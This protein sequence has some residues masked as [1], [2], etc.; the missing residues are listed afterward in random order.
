MK[1]MNAKQ[2][3]KMIEPKTNT[4]SILQ[5]QAKIENEIIDAVLKKQ[6]GCFVNTGSLDIVEDAVLPFR[7]LGYFVSVCQHTGLRGDNLIYLPRVTIL[8]NWGD[9]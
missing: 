4:V 3:R 8:V 2:A 6:S 9:K 7:E 5:L 1:L